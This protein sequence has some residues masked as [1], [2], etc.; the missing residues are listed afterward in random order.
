MKNKG[1]GAVHLPGDGNI[2]VLLL[3]L[4]ISYPCSTKGKPLSVCLLSSRAPYQLC[5]YQ[6]T[7]S[8]P[9]SLPPSLSFLPL[10][11]TTSNSFPL[12]TYTHPALSSPRFL[13]F[14]DS[15]NSEEGRGEEE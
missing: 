4:A 1:A 5:P 15:L 3:A 13:A 14:A 6:N 9:S 2:L 12:A 8:L 11:K 10:R 7:P